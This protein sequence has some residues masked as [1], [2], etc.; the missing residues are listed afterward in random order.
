MR[1]E[2]RGG[3]ADKGVAS[4]LTGVTAIS[5]FVAHFPVKFALRSLLFDLANGAPGP[6]VPPSAVPVSLPI[7]NLLAKLLN[8]PPLSASCSS[9]SPA[10]APACPLFEP[11]DSLRPMDDPRDVV[12]ASEGSSSA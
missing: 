7:L 3:V 1:K 12:R 5:T 10:P 2:E 9:P 11:K 4:Q 6:V 8:P